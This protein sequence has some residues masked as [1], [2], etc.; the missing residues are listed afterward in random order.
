[1]TDEFIDNPNLGKDV[2]LYFTEKKDCTNCN[3]NVYDGTIEFTKLC[4]YCEGKAYIEV[5]TTDTMRLRY[6]NNPR[7]WVKVSN[8]Q[9]MDGRA[10]IIF[11]SSDLPKLMKCDKLQVRDGLNLF[12]KLATAAFPH[13]FGARYSIAFIDTC[14]S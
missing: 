7:N 10:Q 9:F 1:M 13:G 12:Y 5:T 14:S 3:Q 11:Y 2:T 4:P 8:I 6:Y